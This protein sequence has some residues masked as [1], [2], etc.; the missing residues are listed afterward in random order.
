ML[1]KLS[2][3]ASCE[4]AEP[5]LEETSVIFVSLFCDVN[6]PR[7]HYEFCLFFLSCSF[8]PLES[9]FF[10]IYSPPH[11]LLPLQY[12]YLTHQIW[13]FLVNIYF[14]FRTYIPCFKLWSRN[15]KSVHHHVAEDRGIRKLVFS[16]FGFNFG[17]FT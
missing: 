3:P 10:I 4:R 13:R 9:M 8:P 5:K 16:V 15:I 6:Y 17:E 1:K 7:N 14:F 2:A 12:T 11:E